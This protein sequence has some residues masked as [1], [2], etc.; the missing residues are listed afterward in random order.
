MSIDVIKF[1]WELCDK[2]D[3]IFN[4]H[5]VNYSYRKY[6][7]KINKQ[8]PIRRVNISFGNLQDESKEYYDLFTDLDSIEKEKK[9]QDAV[10]DIKGKFGKSSILKGMSLEEHAMQK[11]RNKLIGGHNGE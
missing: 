8:Y 11:K 10:I 4:K 9:L 3:E 7:E 5:K 1:D 2:I 6:I